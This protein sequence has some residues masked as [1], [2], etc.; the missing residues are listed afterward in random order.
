MLMQGA[1]G[2]GTLFVDTDVLASLEAMSTALR[3]DDTAGVQ[4]AT[5]RIDAAHKNVQ[6]I[7]GEVGARQVRLD[8]AEA[9]VESLDFALRNLRSDLMDIGME[10]A[11]TRLVN[12][13][14]SYQ[15]A[16]LATSKILDTTLTNYLR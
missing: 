16:L 3:A 12:R 14:A 4:A 15:A 13:Q 7:V 1:H 6:G 8:V 2:A 5:D 9:N 11:V 10:E